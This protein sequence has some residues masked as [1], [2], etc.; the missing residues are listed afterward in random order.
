MTFD[1]SELPAGHFADS[2]AE[3]MLGWALERFGNRL[4]I[5]SSFGVED[6]ALIDMAAAIRPEVRVF[7]LDT[8]RLHQETYDV[9]D[10][11]RNRYDIE[12]EVM[13]PQA[14]AVQ[15]MVRSCG[16]N[17]FYDSIQ[18][19]KKCCGIRKLEPLGRALAS[20]EA[21]VTGLRR[22]QNV[23]RSDTPKVEIDSAHGG[24]LKLAPLANW[25]GEQVWEYVKEN[26][27][28]YNG[29]HDTGF[30]SIGCEPCTRPIKPDEDERAG[31]WWWEN[32]ETREC[33]LHLKV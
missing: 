5:A 14:D 11:V 17:L 19:R 6:V 20:C 4:V 31:R 22:E 7:T 25:T 2:S 12:I 33:G 28:P 27:V 10:R 16:M 30:P 9:M 1:L 8:G 24:I 32:A 29:L 18:N 13:F 3:E 15:D 23:T 21:W 26:R